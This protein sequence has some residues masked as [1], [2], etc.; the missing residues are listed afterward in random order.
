MT[1]G[2]IDVFINVNYVQEKETM[3]NKLNALDAFCVTNV[4]GDGQIST[5]ILEIKYI[6]MNWQEK[7]GI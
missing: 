2:R 3:L 7:F 5:K 1:K 4:H 6:S